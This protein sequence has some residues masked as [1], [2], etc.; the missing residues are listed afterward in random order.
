MNQ[1]SRDLVSHSQEGKQF[2]G[3]QGG[4][5]T[6]DIDGDG[7]FVILHIEVPEHLRGQGIAAQLAEAAISY[8]ERAQLKVVPQCAYAAAYLKRR[9]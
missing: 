4:L 9:V 7:C 6:Y 8:A 2:T 1:D 3:A 5:L